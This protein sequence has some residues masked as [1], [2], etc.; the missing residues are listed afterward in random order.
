MSS[1]FPCHPYCSFPLA[2]KVIRY[3]IFV[4][5]SS[6]L[7]S[8]T[9]VIHPFVFLSYCH[10]LF[11]LS[12]LWTILSFTHS[13]IFH[14]VT[15]EHLHPSSHN[16]THPLSS[17]YSVIRH[18]TLHVTHYIMFLKSSLSHPFQLPSS[19]TSHP[20]NQSHLSETR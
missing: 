12:F 11:Y 1:I 9:F 18:F 13:S 2:R 4:T 15:Y 7:S 14:T 6:I 8:Y 3:Y 5:D 16:V 10:P 17:E 20:P 19:V